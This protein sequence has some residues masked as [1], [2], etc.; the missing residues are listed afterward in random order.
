M[1]YCSG[2]TGRSLR[3]TEP[4][5]HQSHSHSRFGW[6]LSGQE[7]SGLKRRVQQED[8]GLKKRDQQENFGL[9]R[10]VQQKDDDV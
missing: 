2:N 1:T 5:H 9:K 3:S 6:G 7:D 4:H 10:R 8:S